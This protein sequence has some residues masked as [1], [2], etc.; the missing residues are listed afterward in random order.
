M[1]TS[2]EHFWDVWQRHSEE[3]FHHGLRLMKGNVAD[4]EEVH[5]AAMLRACEMF[6]RQQVSNERAWLRKLLYHMCV[7]VYRQRRRYVDEPEPLA[8]ELAA[9]SPE[10]LLLSAERW[11]HLRQCIDALPAPLREPFVLR[12]LRELPYDEVAAR[13]GLTSCNA[14]KRV[15]LAHS[16]LR[17]RAGLIQG[18]WSAAAER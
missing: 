18:R 13:L 9:P 6:P 7:D 4:A 17:E 1:P 14:R 8:D 16:A 2:R 11:H 12:V 3:L 15:Q 10:V 5:G